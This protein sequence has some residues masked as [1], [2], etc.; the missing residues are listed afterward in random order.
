MREN[1]NYFGEIFYHFV[2]RLRCKLL[3]FAVERMIQYK[4]NTDI[5]GKKKPH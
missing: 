2:N 4:L 5:L 3:H 1:A